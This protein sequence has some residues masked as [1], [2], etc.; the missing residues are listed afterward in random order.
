MYVA[1][2]CCVVITVVIVVATA[3]TVVVVVT[4]PVGGRTAGRICVYH[5][6]YYF[7]VDCHPVQFI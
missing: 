7:L 3:S 6:Q 5:T 4:V 1:I 2:I